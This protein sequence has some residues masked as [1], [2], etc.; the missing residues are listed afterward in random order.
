MNGLKLQEGIFSNKVSELFR[1]EKLEVV[2]RTFT[3]VVKYISLSYL[4]KK[5]TNTR[6][7]YVTLWSEIL[8]PSG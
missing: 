1:W 5:W 6:I 4:I 3:A 2:L 7:K 8:L